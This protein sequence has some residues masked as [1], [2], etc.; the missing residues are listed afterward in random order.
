[1]TFVDISTATARKTAVKRG[2]YNAAESQMGV[3]AKESGT[4]TAI[5]RGYC[6][7]LIDTV[8]PNK[9]AVTTGKAAKAIVISALPWYYNPSNVNVTAAADGNGEDITAEDDDIAF[10]AVKKSGG[11]VVKAGGAIQPGSLVMTAA[12]GEVV[13][14][15][16]S[17][18]QYIIGTY[19]G[20][21]GGVSDG[22]YIKQ[23]CAD[24]D[25]IV[26]DFNGVN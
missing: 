1:M 8:T 19:L 4:D 11:I 13:V 10:Q 5:R 17:G 6:C 7:S 18:A 23:A 15:D 24:H 9:F 16:G 25:L 26:I 2:D 3:F 14:Y 22:A 12:D 20:K 21:P